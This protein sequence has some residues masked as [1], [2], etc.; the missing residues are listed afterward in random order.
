MSV[1]ILAI[2]TSTSQGSL[3]LASRD[4]FGKLNVLAQTSW[5]RQK[6]YGE[7]LLPAISHLLNSNDL[8]LAQLN[9]IAL[10]LGPGSFTGVRLGVAVARAFG[11]TSNL[12]IL[13]FNSL[14]VLAMS[15]CDQSLPIAV[16][17]NAFGNQVWFAT[18]DVQP[19]ESALTE[20]S[21]V[22][23]LKPHQ[24]ELAK[25]HFVLGDG[26]L[27]Y[28]A[29]FLPST[30]E[31]S[32]VNPASSQFPRAEVLATAALR[33][34]EKK[35]KLSWNEVLPLYLRASG[36]EENLKAGLLKALH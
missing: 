2:E 6:S 34:W 7:S 17:Q 1:T 3:A 36:A 30:L 13:T 33:Q 4:S 21:P 14:E 25:P 22:T 11:F 20:N 31:N 9:G 5:T 10:S 12:P 15:A 18:Y 19:T 16:I 32:V 35:D 29:E 26:L 8:Q 24:V 27:H 28:K 23:V